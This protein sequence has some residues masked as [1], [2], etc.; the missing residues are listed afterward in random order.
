MKK[1]GKFWQ[2]RLVYAVFAVLFFPV[3][4]CVALLGDKMK[5]YEICRLATLLPNPVIFLAAAFAVVVCAFLAG[6][7]KSLIGKRENIFWD[8]GLVVL[9]TA[10]YFLNVWIAR[11]T[12][13][14]T[15]WDPDCVRA[16]AYRLAEGDA[17]GYDVYLVIYPNNIVISYLLG[18]LLIWAESFREYAYNSEFIWL[19]LNSLLISV[20]GL[21]ACLTVKRLMRKRLLLLLTAALYI[22]CVGLTPWRI[23]PYTDTYAMAFP[24]LCLCFY[25]YYR[26]AQGAGRKVFYLVCCYLSGAIGGA[27]KANVYLMLVAVLLVEMTQLWKRTEGSLRFVFVQMLLIGL[28][29]VGTK[30][31]TEHIVAEAGLEQNDEIAV[32]WHHYFYMGLNEETTGGYNAKDN[33]MFDEF[34]FEPRAVRNQA[35]LERAFERIRERGFFGTIG[36]WLRKM[37]MTFNDGTFGWGPE[38]GFYVEYP[39]IA[40]GGAKTDF[41][42][43]VFWVNSRYSG[44]YNTLC[45]LVWAFVLLCL[46]GICIGTEQTRQR[47]LIFAVVFLGIFLYL[48]L[49][50]TRARYLLCFAP[51]LV[52][53]ASA[54]LEQYASAAAALLAKRK[55]GSKT[56]A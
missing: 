37:T 2:E 56:P 50:E 32:S 8:I 28:L 11:E 20:A 10:L 14:Y 16:L 36:F 46:P 38:G 54:G 33:G 30:A 13:Y 34:Q 53:Q 22:A 29:A 7:Q 40:K 9:F 25:V 55:A 18:K 3:L 44:R 26:Q 24:V 15:G 51:A 27:V 49:F 31:F 47:N 42:R 35:E 17:W 41:L 21:A 4:L 6:R 43:D 39:A 19:Q 5:Y 45:Q 1:T 23:I 48:L 52:V 12:A